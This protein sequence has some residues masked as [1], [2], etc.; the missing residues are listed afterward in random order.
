MVSNDYQ[1]V[2]H[3][4]VQGTVEEVAAIM[5]DVKGLTRW[6]PSVYLDVCELE[7]GDAQGVGRVVDLYTK[8]WL[9]Y[10]LRWRTAWGPGAQRRVM[11]DST[12]QQPVQWNKAA[13]RAGERHRVF[14]TSGLSDQAVYAILKK[15]G[16]T[17]GLSSFT[18]H[19][20]R[21]TFAGDLLDAGVDL[22][23]VQML[24]VPYK[25]RF[26]QAQKYGTSCLTTPF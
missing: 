5:G 23:T 17:A 8:G 15:R 12:W 3:W 4:R 7:A 22:V 11:A 21:R 20:I 13:E 14:W 9:P 24:H 26:G 25:R 2:T 1:F 18:P 6:W 10:T 16:E 19:D